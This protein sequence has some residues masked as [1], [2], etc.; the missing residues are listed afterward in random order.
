M[1]ITYFKW[2]NESKSYLK[3]YATRYVYKNEIF[4]Q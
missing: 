4:N 1:E 2:G 3:I